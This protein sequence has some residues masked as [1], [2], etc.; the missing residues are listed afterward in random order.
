MTIF[1][2]TKKKSSNFASF[3]SS[4]ELGSLWN[5]IVQQKPENLNREILLKIL[6]GSA[7]GV[8]HLH[9]ENII[10]RDRK[11]LKIQSKSI[12]QINSNQINSNQSN[13]SNRINQ[14]NLNQSNQN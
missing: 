9:K 10:H 11:F 4:Y 8:D 3:C 14:I 5:F 7:S 6:R 13:Q 1:A 2:I 12:N